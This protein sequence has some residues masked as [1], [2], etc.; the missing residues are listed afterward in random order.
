MWALKMLGS[1]YVFGETFSGILTN[2]VKLN[3][4]DGNFGREVFTF[5]DF[6]KLS[7]ADFFSNN[8]NRSV[9]VHAEVHVVYLYK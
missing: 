6:S 7:S 4:Q 1:L 3:N 9:H 2:S 5:V 8:D